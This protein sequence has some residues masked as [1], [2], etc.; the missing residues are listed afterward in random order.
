M[1]KT[2]TQ[3]AQHYITGGEVTEGILNRLEAGVRSFDP[4]LSCSTH[5]VGQM[6]MIVQIQSHNGEVIQ[7]LRRQ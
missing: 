7:E 2:V 5:A 3:I 1:N 6:P 4:C